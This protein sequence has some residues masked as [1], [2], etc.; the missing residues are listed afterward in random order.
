[1]AFEIVTALIFFL[2]E[3]ELIYN[4]VLIS[5]V[6]QGDSIMHIYTFFFIFFPTMVY[7]RVLNIVPCAIQYDLVIFNSF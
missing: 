2:I 7:L 5:A 1:M 4:V 3:V 6:H